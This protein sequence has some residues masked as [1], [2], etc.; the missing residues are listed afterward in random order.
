[1]TELENKTPDE[2]R[3]ALEAALE[4]YPE[5]REVDEDEEALLDLIEEQLDLEQPSS[6]DMACWPQQFVR[7]LPRTVSDQERVDNALEKLANGLLPEQ[8]STARLQLFGDLLDRAEK[9][10]LVAVQGELDSLCTILKRARTDYRETRFSSEEVTAQAVAAHE[11]LEEGFAHWLEAF[12]L[13]KDE[14]WDEAWSAA[15]EGN[16][17]LVAVSL[18]SDSLRSDSAAGIGEA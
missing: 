6:K 15:S 1:M 18:W 2:L 16:R 5:E 7:L 13:A 8:Y 17:C 10:G 11:M 3:S 14:Q 9:K 12:P 4:S